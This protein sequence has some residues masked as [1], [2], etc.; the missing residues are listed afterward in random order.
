M[1]LRLLDVSNGEAARKFGAQSPEVWLATS[2]LDN[3]LE[4]SCCEI[5]QAGLQ[6]STMV[7]GED[8]VNCERP[9][10][11]DSRCSWT[12]TFMTISAR[13]QVPKLRLVL[14]LIQT[15]ETQLAIYMF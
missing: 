12:I 2:L 6:P 11:P 5:P 9:Q 10:L 1:A 3:V 13:M 14:L 15:W 7:V 4:P 8:M